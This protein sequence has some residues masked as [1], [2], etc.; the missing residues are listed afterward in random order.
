MIIKTIQ[1]GGLRTN[2]YIV[3]SEKTKEAVIIDPGDEPEKII[4]VI[5]SEKLKPILIVNTHAHPDH[6]GANFKL[7]E[8]YDI[9]AGLGE[10]DHKMIDDLREY[11]K[12]FS[13]L[14]VDDLSIKKLL[15]DGSI[16]G[17][18]ELKFRV[19]NTPGHSKGGICLFGNGVLFSGDT[20]FAGTYGRTD[21]LGGSEKDMRKSLA[22]LMELPDDTVVYPGHGEP[23]TIS[24]ERE[25]YAKN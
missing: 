22:R 12:D 7:A 17:I 1:V 25:L 19:I 15:K 10:D 13:G 16:I 3:A 20:L 8:K 24:E 18:G 9:V 5:E 21:I 2:C 23:T 14:N 6:V 11:F 4:G